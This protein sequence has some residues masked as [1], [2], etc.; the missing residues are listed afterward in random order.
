MINTTKNIW[1]PG[2]AYASEDWIEFLFKT[3]K[4]KW[5]CTDIHN[6]WTWDTSKN[7][8]RLK[9]DTLEN[10]RPDFLEDIN[11]HTLIL[12]RHAG[13]RTFDEILNSQILEYN[14]PEFF[15]YDPGTNNADI[16]QHINEVPLFNTIGY[17]LNKIIVLPHLHHQYCEYEL[18][19][20]Q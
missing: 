13:L 1:Y 8:S 20:S 7:I 9:F 11:L 2:S 6:N 5:F 19:L 10:P 15:I 17:K 3:Y 4:G 16:K 14:K 12:S 18:T